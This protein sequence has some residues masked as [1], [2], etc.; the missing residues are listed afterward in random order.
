MRKILLYIASTIDGFI[1]AKDGN[2]D[3]LKDYE[4][5]DSDT[6]D[7]G[8]H[9]FL[10]TIDTTL[11]GYNT[12]IAICRF[13]TPFPYPEKTNFVFSKNHTKH[14][15]NPVDFINTNIVDFCSKL[16]TSIGKNIWL[17]GGSQINAVLLNAN[18]IDEITVTFIPAVLGTGIP[19][20]SESTHYKR[21]EM[22]STST[23]ER[24]VV[25]IAFRPES[26]V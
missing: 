15:E 17:I 7:Y 6:N 9:D 4:I 8:Y 24:S 22:I 26:R 16:K 21:F 10:E 18:L 3:W 19:L 23:F 20:F 1:A 13:A 14:D 12:Y 25:Q 11:M 5:P 2:L